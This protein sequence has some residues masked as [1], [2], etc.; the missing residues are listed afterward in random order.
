MGGPCFAKASIVGVLGDHAGPFEQSFPLFFRRTS[1][2]EPRELDG[3]RVGVESDG[4]PAPEHRFDDDRAA[5]AKWVE[6]DALTGRQWFQKATRGDGVE[7]GGI[8]VEAVHV[9]AR[10][11]FGTD[12]E[13]VRQRRPLDLVLP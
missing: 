11:V 2:F 3:Q 6:D 1:Y 12:V 10:T 9:V 13:R 4:A 5:A 7:P 8:A